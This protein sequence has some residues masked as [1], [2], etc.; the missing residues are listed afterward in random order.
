M[1][2]LLLAACVRIP[3]FADREQYAEGIAAHAGWHRQVIPAGA[4]DLVAFVPNRVGSGKN[5]KGRILTVYIE[6]DGLAWISPSRPS[7]DPTPIHP[8]ALQLALR[9]PAMAAWLARPCQYV[10][11]EQRRN[12][13]VKYWTSQRFAPVVIEAGN[14]AI[15]RLKQQF[16][17]SRLIL[18]GYSGGGAVAALI[19]ARR[20]DVIR[21]VTVA[22]NLDIATWAHLQ[23]LSP[24][25]GSL[26]PA[27]LW[28][29]LER[30]PQT[31]YVGDADR[32]VPQAVARAYAARFPPQLRPDIVVLHGFDHRCC[33]VDAWRGAMQSPKQ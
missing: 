9:E 3:A 2:L 13:A 23:G 28:Q 15:S 4:F 5:V 26:N 22:G 33:W 1:L 11:G 7:S 29:S 32:I 16:T 14:I 31:H 8:L 6:G 17:A 20:R 10:Q 12:C 27:D 30:I 24:L 19:A 21:L 25:G 18:V